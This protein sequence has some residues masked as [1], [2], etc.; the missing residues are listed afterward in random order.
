MSIHQSGNNV[1]LANLAERWLDVNTKGWHQPLKSFVHNEITDFYIEH[2]NANIEI[3]KNSLAV[4]CDLLSILDREGN[5]PSVVGKNGN[6]IRNEEV[7]CRY[8]DSVYSQLQTVTL[9]EYTLEVTKRLLPLVPPEVIPSALIVGLGH[10]IGKCEGYYNAMSH[11]FDHAN[12]S[13]R[14]LLA[15]ASFPG[16]KNA[17]EILS[18]IKSHH[19]KMANQPLLMVALR[20][21]ESETRKS[22][23]AP[24]SH[25]PLSVDN[26]QLTLKGI[27][28]EIEATIGELISSLV[29]LDTLYY[30]QFV[31]YQETIANLTPGEEVSRDMLDDR[32]DAARNLYRITKFVT[33]LKKNGGYLDLQIFDFE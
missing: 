30:R 20:E 7:E 10:D 4:I 19:H 6:T 33:E 2:V 1:K 11:T 32:V 31:N 22:E 24:P 13:A 18:V 23:M 3:D 27:S 29:K 25:P 26:S 16:V 14:R 12:L 15:L 28:T 17:E 21:A 8:P 5:C 9:L